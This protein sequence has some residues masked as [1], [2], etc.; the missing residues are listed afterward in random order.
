M[1][2]EKPVRVQHRYRQELVGTAEDVFALLCP[3]REQEWIVGWDPLIV[4]SDS[5]VAERDCVFVTSHESG[6]NAVWIVDHYDDNAYRLGLIKIVPDLLVT[7]V[8]IEVGS[9]EEYTSFAEISY[10]HTALSD[11]GKELVDSFTE[12]DWLRFMQR[13]ENAL[14]HFL[15]TGEKLP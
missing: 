3:V 10:A 8:R 7:R 4:W 14:N 2:I 6:R 13:W 9:V 5:G 11:E 12:E 1:R 15:E